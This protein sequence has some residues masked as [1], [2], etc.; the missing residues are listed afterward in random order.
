MLM[1]VLPPAPPQIPARAA[2]APGRRRVVHLVLPRR[3]LSAAAGA[4][5]AHRE[6]ARE[7]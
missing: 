4:V 1:K 6:Q 5:A 7:G 2:G 3:A